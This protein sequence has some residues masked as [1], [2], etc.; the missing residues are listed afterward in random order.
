MNLSS[1]IIRFSLIT[2]LVSC[3]N[4]DDTTTK[5][6]TQQ[7]E[8]IEASENVDGANEEVDAE[9]VLIPLDQI[10][11]G[12]AGSRQLRNLEPEFFVYRDTPEK[13]AR[14]STP[15]GLKEIETIR[16]RAADNSLVYAI[17]RAMGSMPMGK[18][19]Q[20]GS[21]FAVEGQDLAALQGVYNVL[22]K[23][24]EPQERFS[25][26]TDV[27][28]VFFTLPIQ[29]G[30]R[31]DSVERKRNLVSI[32][33][34][35]VSHGMLEVSWKLALIPLGKLLPGKYQ[36]EMVRLSKKEKDVNQRG[37]PYVDPGIE[38]RIVCRPFSF[39]VTDEP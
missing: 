30:M 13:I 26:G 8:A 24:D 19:A 37:Y 28:V 25:S 34:L 18:N 7:E 33:Y 12:Y 2:T 32:H 22:V 36:V 39:A 20:A 14:Y 17:E 29:P 38:Q 15:E 35:L 10:R 16:Q 21:G 31:I 11:H 6:T 23:G 5:T 27:S 9:V 3:A 4:A 1:R